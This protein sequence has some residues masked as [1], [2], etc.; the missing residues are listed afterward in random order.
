MT[1]F[2][3]LI[4]QTSCPTAISFI[5]VA[6]YV[7]AVKLKMW[8]ADTHVGE[9]VCKYIPPFSVCD[10]AASIIF[11]TFMRGYITS[12]TH[13]VPSAIG[14]CIAHTVLNAKPSSIDFASA[15]C[16]IPGS[17]ISSL[18]VSSCTAFTPAQ[19]EGTF[20]CLSLKRRE[21]RQGTKLQT[22]KVC[23]SRACWSE[24]CVFHNWEYTL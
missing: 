21:C 14:A 1:A 19:P 18:N 24:R 6:V 15:T 2:I 20:R 22:S 11:E 13:V 3:S 17:K 7:N 8:W 16:G 4:D 12:R 9:K 5:V 23:K 10:V